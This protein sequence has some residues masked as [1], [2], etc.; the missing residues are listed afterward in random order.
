MARAF[1]A[2]FTQDDGTTAEVR[3][4]SKDVR[5]WEAAN[6]ASWYENELTD[7]QLAQVVGLAAIRA[8]V[9]QGTVA[10]FV[11]SNDEAFQIPGEV[12]AGP[13]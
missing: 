12:S 1:T 8:G 6:D 13:T 9:Y 2:R 10:D 4:T 7:L 5:A 11:D 3:V